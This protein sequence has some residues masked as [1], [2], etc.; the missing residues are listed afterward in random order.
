MY[1]RNIVYYSAVLL[2]D[3]EDRDLGVASDTAFTAT[4]KSSSV[5]SSSLKFFLV[6]T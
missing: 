2:S 5:S 1:H 6:E 4:V 3:E